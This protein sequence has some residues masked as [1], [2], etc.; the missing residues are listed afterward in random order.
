MNTPRYLL[1]C[2]VFLSG[3]VVM[4]YELVGSRVLG[5]YFGTSTFVWTAIIGIILGS[6]SI[7]YWWGGR[8]ADKQPRLQVLATILLF[9]GASI[10]LVAGVKEFFL[11]ALTSVTNDIR[12]GSVIATTVLFGP[13]SV[14]LGMVSPYVVKLKMLSLKNSG[15]TVGNLY[16]LSTLGSIA[17]T[18]AAGFFLIPYFGTN[19]LLVILACV[20]LIL[21]LILEWKHL[22]KLK[23]GLIGLAW[24]GTYLV[25]TIAQAAPIAV[26]DVDTQYNRVWIYDR[27]DPQT[28]RVA[29]M[30]GINNENHS[31]MFLDSDDLVN[32]YTTFY[33]YPMQLHGNAQKTLMLGG[34]GYSFPKDFLRRY[35]EATIDVVEIDPGVTAL[36]RQYFRLQDDPRMRI[37]HQ[38]AR[39][40]LN[41]SGETYDVIFGDA[42]GSRYGIPYQLTTKEAVEKMY[43]MLSPNGVVMLNIISAID[44]QKGAFL[45]A[46]LATMQSV[47]PQVFLL[48]VKDAA[49]GERVQN[50]MMVA[51]KTPV[52]ELFPP[53]TEEYEAH[54]WSREVQLDL[55]V[56]TDDFA[57]V[58]H[59]IH[60]ALK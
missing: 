44:G 13:T 57:P 26:V 27:V 4:M 56:L 35:P 31:S 9:A 15:A 2:T 30:M 14:F 52:E 11:I 12:L 48:P 34:A 50:V 3:A 37:I 28:M 42:Y 39:V 40:F 49:D 7:G 32:R 23:F 41:G 46:E 24:L 17:G 19:R 10:V 6:L 33:H 60:E 55:P 54:V 45:R 38:D 20:L 8:L 58:D 5:P 25:G 22:C 29:K 53:G 36:A 47:F 21:S 43:T 16:A 1:E 59:Y 18:F 51:L